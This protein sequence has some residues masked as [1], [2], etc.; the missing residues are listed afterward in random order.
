MQVRL[1]MFPQSS[2]S[3]HVIHSSMRADLD[4]WKN[5]SIAGFGVAGLLGAYEY[6]VHVQHH[7]AGQHFDP[8]LNNYPYMKTRSKSYPWSCQDCGLFDQKW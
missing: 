1:L 2:A 7:A 8:E 4:Y 6:Y 5:V 3:N